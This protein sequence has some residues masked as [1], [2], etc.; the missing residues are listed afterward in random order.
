LEHQLLEFKARVDSLE[1]VRKKL[2]YMNA[3]FVGAFHQ[4][5]TFFNVPKGRL[6][7]R[8]VEGK[9]KG[10]L[11]YYEREDI[12]GPKRSKALI[13]E[14]SKPDLF[15]S[16]FEQVLGENVVID[17]RR[18]IYV[19]EDTQIHLDAVE[20]L[21]T[22]VEFER[23]STDFGEDNRSFENLAKKFEIKNEDRLEG[24]YSDIA[25]KNRSKY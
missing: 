8:R 25:L 3:R 1:A 24:S 2:R 15:R 23:K 6:K 19:Y 11:I 5:D 16:F 7:L 17:K 12:R 22:F 10:T 20:S 18:E 14:V 9:A 13:I 4:I 21:G